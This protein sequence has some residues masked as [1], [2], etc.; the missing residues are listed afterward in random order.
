MKLKF[1]GSNLPLTEQQLNDTENRLGVKLPEDY[2][3]FLQIY[4]G[5]HPEPCG[6]KFRD[7]SGS[8]DEAEIAYFLSPVDEDENIFDD[9]DS[10]E[11]RI[12]ENVVPIARDPGGNPIL[13]G[14]SG[15]NRGKIYFWI[16]EP[17]AEEEEVFSALGFVALSF[18]EFVDSLFD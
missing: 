14:V 13:L 15:E 10:Y 17:D 4:H 2:R 7:A 16:D 6:F 18:T 5:A 8:E 11:G 9:A 3:N 12:P 1:T